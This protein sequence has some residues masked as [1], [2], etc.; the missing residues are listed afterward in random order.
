MRCFGQKLVLTS[1]YQTIIL[2]VIQIYYKLF[3]GI[4]SLKA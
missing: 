1:N 4:E 2:L 3:L